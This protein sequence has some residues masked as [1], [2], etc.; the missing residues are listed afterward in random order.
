VYGVAG[1]TVQ[2]GKMDAL[3]KKG[4]QLTVRQMSTRGFA[5]RIANA[6]SGETDSVVK[7]I[8][9]NLIG[10]AHMVPAG[11]LSVN[12]AQERGYSFIHAI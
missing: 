9:A 5:G 10:N 6:N 12:P 1:E 8:A 11:I 3:I 2:A 4:V 7:E